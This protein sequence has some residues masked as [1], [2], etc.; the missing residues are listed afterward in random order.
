MSL[1]INSKRQGQVLVVKV[2]GRIVYGEESNQ[3]RD[4]VKEA[5]ASKPMPPGIVINLSQVP[6]IDSGGIGTVVGLYTSA[7]ASGIEFKLAGAN[8]KVEQV[9]RITHLH[10]VIPV[11]GSESQALASFGPQVASA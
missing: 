5:I 4:A 8:A 10:T 2:S 11:Y 9:L 6:Y 1:Q 7:H 3:L